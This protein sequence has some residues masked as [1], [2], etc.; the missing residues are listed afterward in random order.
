MSSPTQ[1]MNFSLR[2]FYK[3]KPFIPRRLQ[4]LL[5]RYIVR[6]RLRSLED[7]WPIL[8]HAGKMPQGWLGWPNNKKFAV[9]L[10]HDVEHADGVG[11]CKD[12]ARLEAELGF[13]SSFNFVPERYQLP[14]NL[15]RWLTANKF[16]IGVHGLNHDG[17]LYESKQTFFSRA[18]KINQYIDEWG[19]VG[20]RSPAMHH[21]LE[22]IGHLNIEYDLSTFDTDPFEP[23]SRGMGTIFPFFVERANGHGL[24]VE[25]PYTLPQDHTLFVILGEQTIDIWKQKVDWIAEHGGM[26]LVNIHPDYVSIDGSNGPEEYSINLYRELLTYIATRYEGKYWNELPRNVAEYYRTHTTELAR[27]RFPAESTNDGDHK[28]FGI[29][30]REKSDRA[31]FSS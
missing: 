31:I 30:R 19:A 12:I 9:I 26:V 14:A 15:R 27:H 4:L 7:C 5:R 3:V 21:N 25:M 10:T 6:W 22:W 1:T 16:E 29:N 8:E 23:Q 18:E 24:Y 2:F 11:R 28:S 13:T 17:R 20:F